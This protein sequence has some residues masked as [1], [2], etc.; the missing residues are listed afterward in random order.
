MDSNLRPW[1]YT[2]AA[3]GFLEAAAQQ[4][5]AD[6]LAAAQEQ[7][8]ELRRRDRKRGA[9]GALSPFSRRWRAPRPQHGA[10]TRDIGLGWIAVAL[11]SARYVGGWLMLAPVENVAVLALVYRTMWRNCYES[12]VSADEHLE[13]RSDGVSLLGTIGSNALQPAYWELVGAMSERPF[14]IEAGLDEE[15]AE[16]TG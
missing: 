9:R 8:P 5:D 16:E 4:R 10:S 12:A 15:L 14:P 7:F 11:A 3:A 1:D 2:P 6:V 13:E